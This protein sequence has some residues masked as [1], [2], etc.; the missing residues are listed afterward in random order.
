M[1]IIKISDRTYYRLESI[2]DDYVLCNEHK[3]NN[4]IN[5]LLNQSGVR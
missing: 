1:R 2:K 3:M 5:H 4:L